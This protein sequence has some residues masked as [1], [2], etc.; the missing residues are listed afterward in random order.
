MASVTRGTRTVRSTS[1]YKVL[2]PQPQLPVPDD[3]RFLNLP[4]AVRSEI[5]RET[6]RVSEAWIENRGKKKEAVPGGLLVEI[7]SE[8]VNPGL[9]EPIVL[10]PPRSQT[11]QGLIRPY[12]CRRVREE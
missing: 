10:G 1:S 3:H 4:R 8:R 2:A 5:V 11:V 12:L 6:R 9:N 7:W